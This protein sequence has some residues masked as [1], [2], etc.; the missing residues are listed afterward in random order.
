MAVTYLL[1]HSTEAAGI[2]SYGVK[3][4][5]IDGTLYLFKLRTDKRIYIL[6]IANVDAWAGGV[7]DAETKRILSFL[8][9]DAP[10]VH[11]IPNEIEVDSDGTIHC[12]VWG[13]PSELIKFNLSPI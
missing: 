10:V 11:G 8:Y 3:T 1:K 7:S 2:M 5:N 9:S 12:S 4:L 6:D 13:S